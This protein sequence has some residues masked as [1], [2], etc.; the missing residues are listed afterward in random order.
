[1]RAEDDAVIDI[2]FSGH[3]CARTRS[4]PTQGLHG[5]TYGGTLSS[6]LPVLAG[7]VMA[8]LKA[9][10]RGAGAELQTAHLFTSEVL[11]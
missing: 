8:E 1:V 3:I 6:S 2:G 11:L 9:I 4:R 5:A 7:R 10:A